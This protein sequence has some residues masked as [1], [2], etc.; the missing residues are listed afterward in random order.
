MCDPPPLLLGR[1]VQLRVE[2][3]GHVSGTLLLSPESGQRAHV[4]AGRIWG[5]RLSYSPGVLKGSQSPPAA[6]YGL[7]SPVSSSP[8]GS[9]LRGSRQ[10]DPVTWVP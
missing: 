8:E 7:D 4:A 2:V 1:G 9:Q 3:S 6:G 5:A 10:R